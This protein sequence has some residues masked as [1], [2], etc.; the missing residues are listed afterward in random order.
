L[1]QRDHEKKAK[2]CSGK[3]RVSKNVGSKPKKKQIKRSKFKTSRQSLFV[4]AKKKV[5]GNRLT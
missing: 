2:H 1:N 4:Q 3:K 5:K